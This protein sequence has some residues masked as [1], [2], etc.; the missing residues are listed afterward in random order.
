MIYFYVIEIKMFVICAIFAVLY[1]YLHT[2]E[3]N[4]K[5]KGR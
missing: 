2:V 3:L 4:D 1:P 5:R